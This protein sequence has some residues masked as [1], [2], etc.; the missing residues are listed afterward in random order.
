MGDPAEVVMISQ[1][2]L[3]MAPGHHL[4]A[5]VWYEKSFWCSKV[6]VDDSVVHCRKTDR[7]FWTAQLRV[8]TV[9]YDS[10]KRLREW[11]KT[12]EYEAK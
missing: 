4:E 6:T 9:L 3:M 5:L 10:L 8:M 11:V 7:D 1:V 2:T 12:R